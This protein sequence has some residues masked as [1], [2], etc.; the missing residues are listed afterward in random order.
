M[1]QV[2]TFD[3]T[4]TFMMNTLRGRQLISCMCAHNYP[5][6]LNYLPLIVINYVLTYLG[7]IIATHYFEQPST[8]MIV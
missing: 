7:V 6:F 5:P 8:Q 3:Y 4:I 2:Q 1:A